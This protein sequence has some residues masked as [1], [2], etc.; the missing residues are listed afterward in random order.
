MIIEEKN[1]KYLNRISGDFD[2]LKIFLKEGL[3]KLTNY[4]ELK[5]FKSFYKSDVK[6]RG[7]PRGCRHPLINLLVFFNEGKEARALCV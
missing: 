1:F 5:N 7:L 6:P 4:Y 2:N 3:Y